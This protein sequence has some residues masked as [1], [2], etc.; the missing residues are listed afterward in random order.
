MKQVKQKLDGRAKQNQ[1]KK[2]RTKEQK[3]KEI[4]TMLIAIYN[5]T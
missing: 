1:A 2:Y 4:K 5:P 3:R